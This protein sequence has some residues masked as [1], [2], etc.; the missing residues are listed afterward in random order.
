[1]GTYAELLIRS[2]AHLMAIDQTTFAAVRLD[3]NFESL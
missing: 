3:Q 1:M 2:G